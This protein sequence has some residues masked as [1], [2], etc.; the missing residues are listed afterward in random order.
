MVHFMT[1]S[2]TTISRTLAECVKLDATDDNYPEALRTPWKM[3]T[4]STPAIN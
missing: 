3:Q 2:Y 1:R 4:V